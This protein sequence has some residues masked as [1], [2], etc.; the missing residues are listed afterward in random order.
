VGHNCI[1]KRGVSER[2]S[3]MNDEW[4]NESK[5]DRKSNAKEESKAKQRK[6]ARTY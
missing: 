4:R 6:E 3:M 2:G 1:G 5:E